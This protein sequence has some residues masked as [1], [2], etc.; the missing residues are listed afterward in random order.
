MKQLQQQMLSLEQKNKVLENCLD[1]Y[2]ANLQTAQTKEIKLMQRNSE[3]EEEVATLK[4]HLNPSQ[5]EGE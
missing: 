1:L 3:L 5:N 2:K 4:K